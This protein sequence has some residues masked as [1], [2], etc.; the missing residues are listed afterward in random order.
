[1][2][3]DLFRNRLFIG[4]CIL[5]V[6]A[7]VSVYLLTRQT[8]KAPI[9]IDD[10]VEVEKPTAK[11]PPVGDT[12]QGGHW[13]GDEWHAGPHGAD[14][15]VQPE[16]PKTHVAWKPP[17]GAVTKP[18]F[19]TVDPNADPVEEAYKR[20][21]YIKNNP[22]AWGGVHSERATELIAQLMPPPVLIDHD[23]GDEVSALMYELAQQGDPRAAEVFAGLLSPTYEGYT[24]G[25]DALVAIGPPSV[26]YILPYL[27]REDTMGSD[28][29]VVKGGVFDSLS[30][31]GVRY[32]SD[33]GGIVD[34]LI[35]PKFQEIAADENNEH[36]HK[37]SVISAREALS[38]LVQ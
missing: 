31:I 20:L 33:L 24:G 21:E 12:S 22:Y 29:I 10:S 8:E 36:Y 28:W 9:K 2:F 4:V 37:V 35:I 19:P 27:E 17:P 7:V 6:C 1:M 14:E 5:V 34:H 23:H 15:T 16:E 38:R 3:K 18:N 32:R 11:S 13:H 25:G 30:H 26:P